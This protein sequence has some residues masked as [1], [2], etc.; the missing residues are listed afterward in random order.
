MQQPCR[1]EAAGGLSGGGVEPTWSVWG[2][3]CLLAAPERALFW[4][5]L[6]HEARFLSS[7]KSVMQF[8]RREWQ[9]LPFETPLT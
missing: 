1:A 4:S 2:A 5:A 7:E 6:F 9:L 3:V 8:S